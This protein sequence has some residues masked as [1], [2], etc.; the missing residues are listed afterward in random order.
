MQ[1]RQA[2]LLLVALLIL[3]AVS[4]AQLTC[5]ASALSDQSIKQIIDEER[6]ARTDL[7]KPFPKY[8]WAVKRQ[9]CH[10]VYIE[11]GLPEAPEYNQI[12]R[13]NQYGVIVDVQGGDQSMQCPSKT[14][15]ESELAQIMEKER[16]RRNDLPT[17]FKRHK[18]RVDRLRCLYLYFEYSLPETRGDYQVFTIDPFGELMEFYRSQPY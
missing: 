6:A 17:P 11:D 13:L 7:P 16:K 5:V 18:T 9:G 8:K 4:C 10:Y 1:S 15:T 12:F 3:P 2:L 14:F